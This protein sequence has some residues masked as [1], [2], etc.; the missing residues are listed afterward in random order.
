MPRTVFLGIVSDSSLK[1]S[2]IKSTQL[3]EA[4]VTL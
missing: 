3:L 2:I 4:R 1:L